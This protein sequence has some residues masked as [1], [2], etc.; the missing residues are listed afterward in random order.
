MKSL[1]LKV[2]EMCERLLPKTT[3]RSNAALIALLKEIRAG[4]EGK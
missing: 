2:L 4:L 3:E 1:D